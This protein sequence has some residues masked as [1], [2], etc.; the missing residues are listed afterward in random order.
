MAKCKY[1]DSDET[2]E[3]RELTNGEACNC[4]PPQK[5]ENKDETEK[6]NATEKK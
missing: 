2:C 6:T 3:L 1:C 5:T 4:N